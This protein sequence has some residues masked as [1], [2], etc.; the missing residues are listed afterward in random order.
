[1]RDF[2]DKPM[3]TLLL[4]MGLLILGTCILCNANAQQPDTDT[5]FVPYTHFHKVHHELGFVQV[6]NVVTMCVEKE[7][8]DGSKGP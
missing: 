1:M 2:F 5:P 6:G 8:M 7:Y 4:C 3:I